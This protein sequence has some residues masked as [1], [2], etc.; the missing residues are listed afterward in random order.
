M[1]DTACA[2]KVMVA[3]SGVK[4]TLNKL[5]VKFDLSWHVL[6]DDDS[7]NLVADTEGVTRA[8]R[9]VRATVVA[10]NNRIVVCRVYVAM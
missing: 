8:R 2:L 6:R 10:F 4:T 3:L 5:A 1:V 9:D 7:I